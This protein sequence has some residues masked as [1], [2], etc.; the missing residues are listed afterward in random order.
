MCSCKGSGRFQ[1]HTK[2]TCLFA[3]FDV[4]HVVIVCDVMCSTKIA[5]SDVSC[6]LVCNARMTHTH[7]HANRDFTS[8]F[9]PHV[10]HVHNF[11]LCRPLSLGV[12]GVILMVTHVH[13]TKVS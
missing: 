1:K 3:M 8:D 6:S 10:S 5:V 11:I 4:G 13:D 2:L 12:Q 9:I 7:T